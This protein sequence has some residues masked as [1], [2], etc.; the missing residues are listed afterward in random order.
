MADVPSRL[1][2]KSKEGN[3]KEIRRKSEGAQALAGLP[4]RWHVQGGLS[5]LL[6]MAIPAVRP[7][8]GPSSSALGFLPSV[9]VVKILFDFPDPQ[10]SVLIRGKL[11]LS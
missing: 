11:L 6:A 4:Q 8:F 1:F 9:S 3:Q 7:G 2:S 5:S 10:S